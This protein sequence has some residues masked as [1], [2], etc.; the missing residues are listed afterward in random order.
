MKDMEEFEYSYFGVLSEATDLV[1]ILN[2]N[3]STKSTSYDGHTILI[4]LPV[5]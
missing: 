2:G 3:N 4:K 5:I 1:E